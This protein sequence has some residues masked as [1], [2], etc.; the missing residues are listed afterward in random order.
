MLRRGREVIRDFSITV[1]RECVVI[2][3]IESATLLEVLSGWRKPRSG[4]IEVGRSIVSRLPLE[5]LPL[6]WTGADWLSFCGDADDGVTALL[7]SSGIRLD[8]IVRNL[9]TREI[10]FLS[11]VSTL[12]FR[13]QI[14]LLHQPFA[15][16]T[17]SE[18]KTLLGLLEKK[19]SEGAAVLLAFEHYGWPFKLKRVS[20]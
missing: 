15:G 16:M 10:Q 4:S 14:Y 12:L 7:G 3:G 8:K 19:A 17:E 5:K 2:E 11:T 18:A 13:A 1:E 6:Y 9:D 20:V